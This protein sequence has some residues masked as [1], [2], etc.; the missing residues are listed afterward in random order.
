MKRF[1]T[2]VL[3]LAA[4]AVAQET[5]PSGDQ[6]LTVNT[7]YFGNATC[8]HMPK[9]AVPHFFV[10]SSKGRVFF[11]CKMCLA[12]AKK[13]PDAAYA[14]AYKEVKK[15]GNTTDPVS[16]KPVKE[17]VA[18]TY[19]GHEINL[20]DKKN[21]DAVVKNGDIY[22]TLLTKPDVKDLKNTKDPVTGEA[23]VDNVAVL[24]GN[25]LVR[26]SSADSIEAIR[27]DAAGALEKAKKS[28]KPA[29]KAA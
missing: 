19:Q 25:N 21:A 16:G 2:L 29:K 22:L 9:A 15:V 6:D 17:G 27:K 18:V 8:P 26:L 7:I 5:R 20:E 13:D 10:E 4:G 3:A 28:A 23:V 24:I 1:A 11:C 14:E 12:K